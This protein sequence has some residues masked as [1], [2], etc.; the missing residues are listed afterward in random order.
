MQREGRKKTRYLVCACVL[1]MQ[2]GGHAATSRGEW[3]QFSVFLHVF[4]FNPLI[5]WGWKWNYGGV[6]PRPQSRALGWWSITHKEA[7][8]KSIQWHKEQLWVIL[9]REQRPCC[10]SSLFSLSSVCAHVSP[11]SSS[12]FLLI[13]PWIYREVCWSPRAEGHRGRPSRSKSGTTWT[14]ECSQHSFQATYTWK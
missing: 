13:T 10:S 14:L 6:T 4:M 2:L 3:S 9:D 7:L 12:H 8:I 5:V 1:Y 11:S